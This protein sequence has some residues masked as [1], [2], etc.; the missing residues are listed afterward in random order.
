M[1]LICIVSHAPEN[2]TCLFLLYGSEFF[3]R[4][5]DNGQQFCSCISGLHTFGHKQDLIKAAVNWVMPPT[6]K[7][8][9]SDP[10]NGLQQK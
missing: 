2:Q 8:Q 1:N 5:I 9:G 3:G 4:N 6:N 10:P 7:K